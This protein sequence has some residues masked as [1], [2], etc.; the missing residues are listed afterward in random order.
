MYATEDL[1]CI[2]NGNAWKCWTAFARKRK[3]S[4]WE[5]ECKKNKI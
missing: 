2:A 5:W 4:V 1:I 3:N